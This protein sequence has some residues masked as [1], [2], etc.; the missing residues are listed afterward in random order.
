MID[1]AANPTGNGGTAAPAGPNFQGRVLAQYIK[2][3]SFENPNVTKLLNGPGDNP[4]RKFQVDV[5][6]SAL[7]ADTFESIIDFRAE[8]T[9]KIGIIFELELVYGGLFKLEN[10]PQDALEPFLLVNCPSLLFPFVRRIVAD[11]TSDG[12]FPPLLLDPID[13]AGLYMQKKQK[14]EVTAIKP[15]KSS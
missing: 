10:L 13:F 5:R 12:G 15:G 6:A 9:S 2:D 7:S 3:L 1:S 11:V 8:I 4:N 14:G